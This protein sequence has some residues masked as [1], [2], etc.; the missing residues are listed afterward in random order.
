[1]NITF[2]LFYKIVCREDTRPGLITI[3]GACDS[4]NR[5]LKS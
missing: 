2:L 1:M 5:F 4:G 3:G